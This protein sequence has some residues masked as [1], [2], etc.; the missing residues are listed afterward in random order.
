MKD[1]RDEPGGVNHR[2]L[3]YVIVGVGLVIALVVLWIAVSS[4]R[5]KRFASSSN[6]IGATAIV[7]QPLTPKGSVIVEGEVWLAIAASGETLPTNVS[8]KVVGI[9]EQFLMV[10]V[11]RTIGN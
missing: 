9:Q 4:R 3:F 2:M 7:N 10:E 5:Q 8:V 11:N 1:Y 6:L